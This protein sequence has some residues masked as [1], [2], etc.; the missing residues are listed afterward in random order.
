MLQQPQS[1]TGTQWRTPKWFEELVSS[2]ED[3]AYHAYILHLNVNDYVIPGKPLRA[4]LS[5][6]FANREVVCFYNRAEGITFAMPS[7]EETAIRILGLNQ[8]QEADPYLSAIGAQGPAKT[9][10]ELPRSPAQ[11]IPLLEQL[12]LNDG[13][14]RVAVVIEFAET[15][16]PAQDIA[17]M[18]PDDRTLLVTLQ[19]W[20]ANFGIGERGNI[21]MMTTSNLSDLNERLR[22]AS[23]KWRALEIPLP[24]RETRL[25]FASWYTNQ[26]D[27]AIE[28]ELS[29]MQIANATAGLNLIHLE[30]IFLRAESAGKLS[31]DLIREAK[32]E[33]IETEYSGILEVMEPAFGFEAV[34][35]L[36]AL[37]TYLREEVVSPLL[38]GYAEEAAKGIILVGP[39][40][41]GKTHIVRA[42]AKETGF[43][44]VALKMENILG[45]IVG[46][47][48][49]NLKRALSIVRSLSP[50][51]LFVDEL[52]QSDIS[53]RGNT[54]GN[55][56]AKNLFNM[57]LQFLGEPGLRG[58]LIFVG[59]SNRPDLLDA[60]LIRSGRV[61]VVCPVLLPNQAERLDVLTTQAK[62]LD[63]PVHERGLKWLSEATDKWSNADLFEVMRSA[64]KIARRAGS[65]AADGRPFA[66]KE[67]FEQAFAD[68]RPNTQNADYFSLLAV[69]AT[70]KIS[71]LP[72][73][74]RT[75]RTS[76]AILES[77]IEESKPRQRARREF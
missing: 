76:P 67:H 53:S 58:K 73:E 26:P 65:V 3:A 17:T 46:T 6:A 31:L 54:S 74:Y 2:Y 49:R 63:C 13:A 64:R 34:G 18:A 71:L 42:L 61:D 35:G 72:E 19:R 56:V 55:P 30:D 77:K 5:A 48:E 44:A 45:G 27:K 22:S 75:L 62:T 38:S 47:S 12:L 57:I 23:Y 1:E 29:V 50:V 32:R 66:D 7:M 8:Q 51:V 20:G 37:K 16:L 25:N 69:E 10:I 41:T 14:E 28:T 40:G 59:A 24:D 9:K 4:Y 21:A 70:T 11:A 36:A 52:D 15:L 33:I 39:P 43:N 68:M 60:A